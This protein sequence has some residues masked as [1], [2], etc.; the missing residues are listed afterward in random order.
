MQDP[1]ISQHRKCI[2]SRADSSEMSMT[3]RKNN[4]YKFIYIEVAFQYDSKSLHIPDNLQFM[5]I[6][7]YM[8]R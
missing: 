1:I 3:D 2:P 4:I 5:S 8:I 7:C 6:N